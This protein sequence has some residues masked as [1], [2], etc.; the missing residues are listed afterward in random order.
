MCHALTLT[1]PSPQQGYGSSVHTQP[2]PVHRRTPSAENMTRAAQLA[3]LAGLCY[4]RQELQE[5]ALVEQGLTL[6]GRGDTSFTRHAELPCREAGRFST[7]E[8]SLD[9]G[10]SWQSGCCRHRLADRSENASS[11]C[12]ASLGAARALIACVCGGSSRASGPSHSRL[13][14]PLLQAACWPMQVSID[15]Q[16]AVPVIQP[17]SVQLKLMM[18]TPCRRAEHG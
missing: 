4:A 5:A 1:I 16:L 2:V 11:C 15:M 17:C 13:K 8:P 6:L 10:G 18:P 14:A 7:A 3:A 9:A 12:V